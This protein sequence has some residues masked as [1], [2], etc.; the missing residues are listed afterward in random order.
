VV[1]HPHRD[2]GVSKYYW[3]VPRVERAVR[4]GRE[5]GEEFLRRRGERFFG[6]R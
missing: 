1:L 4:W 3:N 2:L 6:R 5:A